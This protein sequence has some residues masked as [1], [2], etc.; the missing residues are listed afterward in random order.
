M[1]TI[2]NLIN[3]QLDQNLPIKILGDLTKINSQPS[4]NTS[5]AELQAFL[6]QQN[7]LVKMKSL[8]THFCLNIKS[9]IGEPDK[10]HHPLEELL[11]SVQ[12]FSSR[13]M[14]LPEEI[15]KTLMTASKFQSKTAEELYRDYFKG[16]I[17]ILSTEEANPTYCILSENI[18]IQTNLN[19]NK[20]MGFSVYEINHPE[21]FSLQLLE[22]LKKNP[23]IQDLDEC[24]LNLIHY[25]PLHEQKTNY[26]STIKET[27]AGLLYLFF[28]KNS[29]D[30]DFNM[31]KATW[32]SRG[33]QIY[34]N[35]SKFD[36]ERMLG[37][38]LISYRSKP[39]C[40]LDSQE[41]NILL[42]VLAKFKGSGDLRKELLSF[43]VDRKINWSVKDDNQLS[44]LELLHQSGNES[45]IHELKKIENRKNN[46][47]SS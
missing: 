33:R 28:G 31:A 8:A 26:W 24:G 14:S 18:W 22:K 19:Q 7:T 20:E 25:F 5:N 32:K 30:F 38:F 36:Q 29:R 3:H 34:K 44:F 45:V 17:I 27:F 41:L 16:E 40:T 1:Y 2:N 37:E 10:I 35:W 43:F 9:K 46:L 13:K 39:S 4:L 23:V 21:K 15:V 6:Q 11:E 47:P 12:K 42:F